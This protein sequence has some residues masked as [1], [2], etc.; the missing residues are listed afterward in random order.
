MKGCRSKPVF[1]VGCARSGTTWLY[2]LLLS[3]GGF[4]IYRSETQFYD[5]FGPRFDNFSNERQLKVFLDLWLKSEFFLRSG[6]DAGF[7][8]NSA[9][10]NVNSPG[11]ML[12]LFMNCI[13]DQQ[14]A[15]RWAENT[16]DYAL[17][18][19]EIKRDFPDALFIHVVRD[20][21]DVAMS[22]AKQGFIK[23]FRWHRK[24]PELAAAAYWA[25]ITDAVLR[26]VDYL[27]NDLLIVHYEDLLESLDSTLLRI[28]TFID[29]PIDPLRINSFAVGSVL[30]PN[31]SFTRD[32]DEPDEPDAKSVPRW[33][34]H[35]D[36]ETL[37]TIE[38]VIRRSLNKF[39][40]Q[41]ATNPI[42]FVG[43]IRGYSLRFAY[44]VRF[45]IRYVLKQ[46]AVFGRFVP[47]E[48]QE[49]TNSEHAQD[50]TTRPKDNM[51]IIRRLVGS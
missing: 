9:L 19:M 48:L 46:L 12:K 27:G 50:P 20:G 28:A 4:A 29:K 32:P 33:Q 6:L 31:S 24:Q 7:F 34:K 37:Q 49:A 13:C 38:N 26:Q 21:R 15:K 18:I 10:E 16:P 5:R 23:P 47:H 36:Q 40:Y 41:Q 44:F 42:R 30:K 51:E 11:T 45:R 2:H 35:C 14:S 22:L 17:H 43:G 39:G 8:R 1:I 25:W 3:S